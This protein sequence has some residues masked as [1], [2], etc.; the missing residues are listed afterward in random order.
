MTLNRQRRG[1]ELLTSGVRTGTADGSKFQKGLFFKYCFTELVQR[2][3]KCGDM[4]NITLRSISDK[5]L[6]GLVNGTHFYIIIYK[7]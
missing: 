7:S 2:I 6:N 4:Q 1:D 3:L 5:E